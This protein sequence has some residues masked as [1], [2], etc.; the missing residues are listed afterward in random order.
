MPAPISVII[1]TLNATQELLPTLDSLLAGVHDG[2][3]REVVFA[4]GGSDDGI[5]ELAEATGANV[6]RLEHAGRG[7]QLRAGADIAK[8]N[9][10]LFLHA[11]TVLSEDWV[12]AVRSHLKDPQSAGYFK[13]R[14][15]SASPFASFVAGWANLRSR[16]FHLPYGD[17]GLLIHRDLYRSVG[18]F[19]DQPLMEDVEICRRLGR[20][21]KRLPAVAV[22]SPDR[23][24][25]DGWLRRG[26]RNI[27]TL[28]LY[29][30]GWA[31]E[32][33]MVFYRGKR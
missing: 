1:P 12:Q 9:W 22:T 13:L 6:V 33:L 32:R 19:P 10:Y 21:F 15:D 3:V 11:D 29:L 20:K 30:C 5:D 28:A 25:R 24:L 4:D 2:L 14:F 7:G 18:G 27:L 16:V 17:Q 8:G 26:A 31:P 23:Y